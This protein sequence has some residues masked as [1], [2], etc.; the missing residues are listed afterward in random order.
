MISFALRAVISLKLRFE[1][2]MRNR[3]GYFSYKL[4]LSELIVSQSTMNLNRTTEGIRFAATNPA[5]TVAA[6]LVCRV[7]ARL[8]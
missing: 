6:E 7:T 1:A 2:S 4:T 5:K 3:N 8:I